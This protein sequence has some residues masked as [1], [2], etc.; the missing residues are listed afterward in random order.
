MAD[1][2][3]ANAGAGVKR[4][5]FVTWLTGVFALSLMLAGPALAATVN[6][7]WDYNPANEAEIQGYR[8]YY[9]STS[10]AGVTDPVDLVSAAPYD[11]R[12][13]LPD[14]SLRSHSIALLPGTYYFRMTAYGSLDGSP[15]DSVF[16]EEISGQVGF[17]DVTNLSITVTYP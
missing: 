12:I 16:S 6:L 2:Y 3:V 5:T 17:L 15:D 14:P 11:T 9:G 1:N 8:I 13:E 7:S 4:R 10:Q